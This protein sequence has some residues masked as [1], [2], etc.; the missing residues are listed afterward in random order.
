MKCIQM[1]KN[2]EV[3]VAEYDDSIKAFI[4]IIEIKKL[5][6]HLIY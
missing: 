2:T 6:M 4:E 5:I 1:N 3:F